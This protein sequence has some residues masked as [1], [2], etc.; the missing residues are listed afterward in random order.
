M[1]TKTALFCLGPAAKGALEVRQVPRRKP[2]PD[3]VE[4]DVQGA[5]VNPIDVR[6]K[7]AR[8]EQRQQ[9]RAVAFG[10]DGARKIVAERHGARRSPCLREV[11]A[12]TD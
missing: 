11:N 4:I 10:T 1:E 9:P 12:F 3:E 5:S 2:A 6:R 8:A 7:L